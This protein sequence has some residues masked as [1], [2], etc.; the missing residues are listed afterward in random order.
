MR[1]LKRIGLVFAGLCV[2]FLIVGLFLPATWRAE[3]SIV[4][5]AAPE[6][7]LPLVDAPR[8]WIEWAPWTPERYPGMEIQY[9]EQE[10]GAGA[11]WSWRG[12][13]SGNGRMEITRSDPNRGIDYRLAFEGMTPAD[14]SLR[15]RPVDGGTEV[16]WAMW[17]DQG[18]NL[19]GRYFGLM[20]DAWMGEDFVSGLTRL[21]A[22]AEEAQA[23]ADEVAAEK[24]A[25]EQAAAEVEA[26]E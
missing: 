24:A 5:R 14:G 3:R 15:F 2:L 26:A 23:A 13:A 20:M 7:I 12:E 9:G 11:W 16:T 18:M 22:K 19:I 10:R 8:R 4:I 6:R 21:K 17:G 25:A 1:T